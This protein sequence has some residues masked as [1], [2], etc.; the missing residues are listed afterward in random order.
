MRI[1]EDV[2]VYNEEL[3]KIRRDLHQIPELAFE[4]Y[5]TSEYIVNYLEKLGITY[6]K[7]VAKT[8]VIAFFEGKSNSN[9][10]AFRA[11]MDALSITEKNDITFK[12]KNG[13]KMHA[14]GHDGH[15]AILLGLARY[16]SENIE[17]LKTNVVLI[18]QPAEEGPGGALPLI[19]EGILEKYNIAEIYG[20]HIFPDLDEGKIGVREGVM[21]AQAGEFDIEIRGK[22]AH[23]AQPHKSIDSV[24]VMAELILGFQSIVSRNISPTEAS[25]LTVGKVFAGDRRNIIAN[26]AILEGI[27]RSFRTSTYNKIKGRIKDYIQGLEHIHSCSI[28]LI[29]RDGY[30][31]VMNDKRLTKDFI[32]GLC[33]DE[34]QIIEP[35]MLAEDFSYYQKKIP[36]L[37][38]FLGARNTKDDF[39]YPL[40]NDRFNF[41]EDI[42]NY[43]LSIYVRILKG[44]KIII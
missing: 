19:N 31:S 44:K 17:K 37:F 6:E 40:H 27:I 36:G 29:F 4:E 32:V 13:G 34:V 42:L 21:M 18:F 41:D 10:I 25:V 22:S 20:L 38:F 23:A 8:G 12:S 5:K 28:A 24:L 16:L 35:L 11:D 7:K 39:I 33:Q 1:L 3:K 26:S 9:A 43:G 15:M 14:C 2:S 30:P